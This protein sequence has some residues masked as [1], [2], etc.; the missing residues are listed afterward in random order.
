MEESK[1]QRGEEEREGKGVG[2]S[3]K[4]RKVEKTRKKE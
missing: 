4:E 2:K 1:S 3:R